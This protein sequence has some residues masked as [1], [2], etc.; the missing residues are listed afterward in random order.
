MLERLRDGESHRPGTLGLNPAQL[1]AVCVQ[2]Y[3]C[4]LLISATYQALCQE[5]EFQKRI[6]HGTIAVEGLHSQCHVVQIR[7]AGLKIT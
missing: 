4:G 7:K 5:S 2:S 1:A 3:T 6:R